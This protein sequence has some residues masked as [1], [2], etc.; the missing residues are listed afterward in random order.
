MGVFRARAGLQ[1]GTGPVSVALAIL[2]VVRVAI[3]AA[4]ERG[5]LRILA[6]SC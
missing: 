5:R 6:N 3:L 4:T 2:I 1:S